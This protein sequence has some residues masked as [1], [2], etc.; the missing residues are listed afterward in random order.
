MM[1]QI[2]AILLTLILV[3]SYACDSTDD[4]GAK[5]DEITGSLTVEEGKKQLEEN[6]IKVL[7]KVESFESDDALNDI[8]ELA[9]YLSNSNLEKSSG[10]TK[11]MFGTIKNIA[12]IQNDSQD[13]IVFNAK[14]SVMFFRDKPLAN[15]FNDEKG[16]YSWNPN[17]EEFEKTGMSDDIIYNVNYNS[18]VA[19]FSITDFETKE[20]DNEDLDE[21][22]T[23]AAASLKINNT[24]VF[25]QKYSGSF[26]GNEV[27][28]SAINNE[29]AIGEF[30][31]VTEVTNADNKS[32]KQSL[33]FKIGDCLI[34]GFENK[35]N[36]NF[37]DE[38]AEVDVLFDNTTATIQVLDAKIVTTGIDDNFDED[39]DL[40]INEAVT[41]LNTNVN[42]ELSIN[43]KSIAKSLFYKDEDTY[44]TF[45]FNPNTNEFDEVEM[46]EDILNVKFVFEDETS[47]DFDTYFDGSFTAL[48]DK[49][50]T[51]FDAYEML[52]QDLE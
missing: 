7:D 32:S 44:T 42:S 21:V 17:T 15:D 11:K 33:N 36:G 40:T 39:A 24:T 3:V 34:L 4:S 23:L 51:V 38:E 49:L 6:S 50:E 1:K 35:L 52:F 18:N 22:P 46:T 12:A 37:S 41:L 20:T 13:P 27:I 2:K 10:F 28:P 14:Q 9:E 48:E 19:I 29:T 30:S 8:V 25:T 47:S 26:N 31:F 16:I 43:N 45:E 5:E